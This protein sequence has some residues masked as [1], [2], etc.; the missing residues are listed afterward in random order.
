[1]DKVWLCKIMVYISNNS[2]Y[3]QKNAKTAADGPGEQAIDVF[4]LSDDLLLA[5]RAS[6]LSRYIT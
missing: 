1:M 5:V 6:R 3:L 2:E 4:G